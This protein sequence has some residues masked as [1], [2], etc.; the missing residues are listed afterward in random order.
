M[1]VYPI[2]AP[3]RPYGGRDEAKRERTARRNR[4]AERIADYVNRRLESSTAETEVFV[5]GLV[6]SKLGLTTE[7]VRDVLTEIGGGN[8]GVTIGVPAPEDR[9][10]E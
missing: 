1:L 2:R 6:A 5:Y 9:P 4:A 7:V 8:T 10:S 3:F